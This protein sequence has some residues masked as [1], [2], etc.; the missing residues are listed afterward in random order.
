MA[1]V[2]EVCPVG[3]SGPLLAALL[4]DRAK[5]STAEKISPI[6]QLNQSVL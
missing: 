2:F 6:V 4:A 5:E 3:T 1:L